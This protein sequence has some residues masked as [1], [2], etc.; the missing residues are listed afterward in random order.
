MGVPRPRKQL[1]LDTNLLLDLAQGV[2]VAHDFRESFQAKGYILRL[3]PTAVLELH[4]QYE[5]GETT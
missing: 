4:E 5:N 2:D 3:S 1:A